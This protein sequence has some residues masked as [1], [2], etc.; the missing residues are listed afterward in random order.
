MPFPSRSLEGCPTV[1][2]LFFSS[3][4]WRSRVFILAPQMKGVEEQSLHQTDCHLH[5]LEK[6][7]EVKQGTCTLTARN[8]GVFQRL[9]T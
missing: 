5:W 2:L 6:V 9:L 3:D 1:R 4:S 8:S 7:L